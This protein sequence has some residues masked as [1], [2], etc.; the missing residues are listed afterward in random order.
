MLKPRT[1]TL[2]DCTP[3]L[4]TSTPGVDRKWSIGVTVGR[5]A[6]SLFADDRHASW[7]FESFFRSDQCGYDYGVERECSSC[8]R[9]SRHRAFARGDANVIQEL[10]LVTEVHEHERIAAGGDVLEAV[11]AFLVRQAGCH[12][13]AAARLRLDAGARQTGTAL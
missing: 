9:G 8:Q 13:T 6:I 12:D 5:S 11:I 4:I 2:V 7:S 1:T 10:R 3:L